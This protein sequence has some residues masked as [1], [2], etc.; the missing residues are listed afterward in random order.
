MLA[1]RNFVW[2]RKCVVR[3]M[4]HAASVARRQQP[5]S[6]DK[7]LRPMSGTQDAVAELAACQRGAKRP[8]GKAGAHAGKGAGH[9]RLSDAAAPRRC[10]GCDNG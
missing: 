3:E 4:Q 7:F 10:G 6:S 8:A 2:C 1:M 9:G 5:R